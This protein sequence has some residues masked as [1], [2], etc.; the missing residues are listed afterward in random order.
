MSTS[1]CVIPHYDEF[2]TT[3][4]VGWLLIERTCAADNRLGCYPSR[5]EAEA[6]RLRM[7]EQASREQVSDVA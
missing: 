4:V 2:E 3:K 7:V 6:V 1:Y 5:E